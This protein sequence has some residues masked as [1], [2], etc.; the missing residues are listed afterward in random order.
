MK[1]ARFNLVLANLSLHYLTREDTVRAFE[2]IHQLLMADGLFAFRLNASDD[3]NYGSPENA[4]S[5]DRIE[6]EGIRKQFFT[7]EK[8]RTVTED[9][10]EILSLEKMTTGRY[11]KE[12]R[13]FEGLV[14]PRP[15]GSFKNQT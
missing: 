13:L 5:W 8:I 4:S 7:E 12:K 11:G 14:R 1:P 2:T 10:F 15:E 6:V 3:R 9:R